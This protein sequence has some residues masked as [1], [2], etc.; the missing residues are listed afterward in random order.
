MGGSPSQSTNTENSKALPAPA[1]NPEVSEKVTNSTRPS[2]A[3]GTRH[4]N[5]E[6]PFNS[7]ERG[8]CQKVGNKRRFVEIK[9]RIFNAT[10]NILFNNFSIFNNLIKQ[11]FF[12]SL[13]MFLDL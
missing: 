1:R 10:S 13:F 8:K 6:T 12:R 7:D 4:G 9:N 3:P 2:V 5:D 11:K